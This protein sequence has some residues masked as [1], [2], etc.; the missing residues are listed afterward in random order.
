MASEK[1]PIPGIRLQVPINKVPWNMPL[2][3]SLDIENLKMPALRQFIDLQTIEQ[4]C[5]LYP[6][7]IYKGKKYTLHTC[8]YHEYVIIEWVPTKSCGNEVKVIQ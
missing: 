3:I 2:P 1:K 6:E 7:Y 5:T 4:Q 8:D